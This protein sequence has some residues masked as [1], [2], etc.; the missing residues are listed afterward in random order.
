M[1]VLPSNSSGIAVVITGIGALLVIG[2]WFLSIFYGFR[3][4]IL[5]GLFLLFIPPYSQMVF[6]FVDK[7]NRR[8]WLGLFAIGFAVTIVGSLFEASPFVAVAAVITIV[9]LVYFLR[10]N[11]TKLAPDLSPIVPQEIACAGI[12]LNTRRFD[13]SLKQY[14]KALNSVPGTATTR[15]AIKSFDDCNQITSV[16]NFHD[17]FS[18]P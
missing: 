13:N 8:S 7:E 15:L 10:D 17:N 18:F 4:R 16:L 9:I 5:W 1:E 11:L 12:T 14:S 3:R 6:A 2:A